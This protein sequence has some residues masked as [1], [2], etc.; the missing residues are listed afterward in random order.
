[1]TQLVR[2]ATLALALQAVACGPKAQ[3]MH[4]VVAAARETAN[5][6]ALAIESAETTALLLYRAEQEQVLVR[7]KAAAWT[8]LQAKAELE[9]V[10]LWW[11]PV[12]DAFHLAR[13]AH[14]AVRASAQLAREAEVARIQ[15]DIPQL[16]KVAAELGA[17]QDRIAN[18]LTAARR[19][20]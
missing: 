19:R 10:R 7:A 3:M 8:T 17:V 5:G 2:I 6:A 1:M 13:K 11:K 16:L 12:W 15:P 18:L 9:R 14:A 4:P 20:Q